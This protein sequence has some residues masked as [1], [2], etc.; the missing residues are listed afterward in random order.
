MSAYPPLLPPPISDDRFDLQ[1][2][3]LQ[4]NFWTERMRGCGLVWFRDA[5]WFANDPLGPMP[6]SHPGASE[7][8]F[9]AH[10]K[11]DA[12]VGGHTFE[13]GPGNLCLIPPDT[14]HDP[15]GTLGTDLGL[16]C[17]VSPNWRGRRWDPDSAVDGEASAEP[18]LYQVEEPRSIVQDEL[19]SV[20]CVGLAPAA[21]DEHGITPR[22]E[23]VIYMLDGCLSVEIDN[24]VGE[25]GAHQYVHV[26]SNV[27]HRLTNIGTEGARY[28]SV[29]STD[30][31]HDLN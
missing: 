14:F 4:Q 22:R 18:A 10:G 25:L 3:G 16:F 23:R 19:L 21:S 30:P 24:L 8:Y 5:T 7:V 9:V 11:L 2:W 13:M 6:H 29:W 31:P 20:E 26:P 17:V 1:A 12:V 28:L 15:R 27:R